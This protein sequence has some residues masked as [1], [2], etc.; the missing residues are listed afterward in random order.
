MSARKAP[1]RRGW[2]GRTG[3]T[4]P[5][6]GCAI[7]CFIWWGRDGMVVVGCA[8]CPYVTKRLD[9]SQTYDDTT[10]AAAVK[11]SRAG[12]ARLCGRPVYLAA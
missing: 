4:R 2:A 3:G 10:L 8:H 12:H 7:H 9:V 11:S 1:P 6:G 5:G